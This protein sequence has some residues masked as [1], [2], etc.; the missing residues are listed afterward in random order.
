MSDIIVRAARIEEIKKLLQFEQLIIEYERPFVENMKTEYFNYY[1]LE[2]L[3]NSDD[4]E[5]L[6]AELAG[7]LIGS[8]YAKIKK[9]I[10]YMTNEFHAF[11]GY[12]YVDPNYRWKGVNQK[13]VNQLIRWSNHK[14]MDEVRLTVFAKNDSAIKAYDKAG[15]DQQVIEMRMN[16]EK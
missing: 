9:S 5:V 6:V 2:E 4:A 8:G 13:I 15:F 7:Q 1:S 10:N 16:I 3:I 14:G 12:M 11:L